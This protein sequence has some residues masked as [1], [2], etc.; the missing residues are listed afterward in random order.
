MQGQKKKE[1][2]HNLWKVELPGIGYFSKEVR[3]DHPG[4]T[5][6]ALTEMAIQLLCKSSAIYDPFTGKGTTGLAAI[7]NGK[8][9]VGSELN[10]EYI[11]FTKI[12]IKENRPFKK[13]SV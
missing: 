2:V 13:Q 8:K 12:R 7:R 4:Y 6:Y 10:P 1:Q 9:F 3:T 5:T 11:E